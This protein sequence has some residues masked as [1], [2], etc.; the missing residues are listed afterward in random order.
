MRGD[1]ALT[2]LRSKGAGGQSGSQ[3]AT[4]KGMGSVRRLGRCLAAIAAAAPLATCAS[5]D[6]LGGGL[7]QVDFHLDRV[8]DARLA[9]VDL[10]GVGRIEQLRPAD[11]LVIADAVGRGRLPLRF[12]LQVGADNTSPYR[13][14][15]R[16]E[17]LEWTLLL[18]GRETVNGVLDSGVVLDPAR[19]TVVPVP[20]ELDLLRFFD[21]GAHDLAR[22]ALRAVGG[23]G[24]PVGVALRA[25]PTLRTPL[26]PIR[27]PNEITIARREVGAGR[28]ASA[29]R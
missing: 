18:D 6:G 22:L 11:L 14:D 17:R 23:G 25:R 16:L 15:L 21:D 1:S 8:S 19:T 29:L 2:A 27:F 10:D 13:L 7:P 28:A 4:P 5:I 12:D 3:L 20:V 9:G 26:G 24:P